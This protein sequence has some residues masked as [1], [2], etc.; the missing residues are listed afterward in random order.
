VGQGETAVVGRVGF[1]DL[2][3]LLSLSFNHE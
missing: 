1:S 3:G 2:E